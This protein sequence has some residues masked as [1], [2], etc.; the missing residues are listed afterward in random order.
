MTRS[1]IILVLLIN[2]KPAAAQINGGFENWDSTYTNVYSSQLI[3]QFG[4]PNPLGGSLL[5][6]TPEFGYGFSRTTD[7]YS[8]NY[9]VIIHNWYNYAYESI[10]YQDTLSYRPGYL[11]GYFKYITGGID[12][13]STGTATI[14]LTR[15]NGI[16]RDTI[17]YGFLQFD[18]TVNFTPFQIS[19][20]YIS[21][22]NPDSIF[23]RFLNGDRVCTHSIICNLLY[24]DNISLSDSPLSTENISSNQNLV[25]V[26]P[27]PASGKIYIHNQSVQ[28]LQFTLFNS[29]GEK[30]IDQQIK[31]SGDV[32]DI[33]KFVNGIY[34]YEVNSVENIYQTGK[35]VKQ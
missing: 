35:L 32:I 3:N 27:N 21:I 23:I 22:L 10:N 12:G 26:F 24:L 2:F 30:I 11:Q 6:W 17:A 9:S 13:I 34:F 5:G 7:S 28:A 18:S 4:V 14:S 20:N 16:S 8:G 15:F 25:S 31:N 19:L 29:L 33:S 1:I